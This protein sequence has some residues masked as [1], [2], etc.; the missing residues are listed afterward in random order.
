VAPTS[1][2]Y[3][4][5]TDVE[6]TQLPVA[7]I[8][9]ALEAMFKEKGE[10]KVEMPPKPGIHP[11][12]DAFIHA[13]PAYIPSIEAAGLK[14][15]SD[16]TRLGVVSW[17]YGGSDATTNVAE[18]TVSD[19]AKRELTRFPQSYERPVAYTRDGTRILFTREGTRSR[20]MS[21]RIG[22]L[23]ARPAASQP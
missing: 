16:G 7:E 14:W 8:I 5:R 15:V 13:M 9:Q 23:L 21:V 6:A 4:S 17:V 2:L 22:E 12:S 10:G 1:L 20:V 18:V 3:L 19:G 11:R